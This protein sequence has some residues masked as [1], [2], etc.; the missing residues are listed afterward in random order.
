SI[1]EAK[2]QLSISPQ[3]KGR[4]KG[5]E[6]AQEGGAVASAADPV[7]PLIGSPDTEEPSGG[8]KKKIDILLKAMG[9]TPIMKTKKW[10]VEQ[11]RTVQGLIDFIKKFLKLMASE[12]L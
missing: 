9:D 12:Q 7:P 1:A 11:S 2:E 4:N 5:G 8:T 3:S 10:A 6:E